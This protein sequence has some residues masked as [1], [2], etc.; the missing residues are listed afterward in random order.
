MTTLQKFSLVSLRITLGWMFFYA[1]I[2]KVLDPAWSAAGY[3]S[4]AKTM[5]G[6]YQ[7]VAS[8]ALLPFTN[9]LNEWGLTLIGVALILGIG[10]RLSSFLGVLMMA[11]YYF[12]TLDFPYPDA[13][14]FI[15]DQ[16]IIY[17]AG[18]LV[19][20]GFRAGRVCGLENWCS[21]LPICSKFPKLRAWM[22]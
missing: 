8:P 16:H 18:L 19:L 6:F 9:F 20:A 7:W 5:T 17:A 10:V 3:L 12:P 4:A 2:T 13:H 11:L 14:S 22:G 15:V 21:D 1:G